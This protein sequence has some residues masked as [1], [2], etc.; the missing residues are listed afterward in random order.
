MNR[1][2]IAFLAA[3]LL[4]PLWAPAP[5]EAQYFGR[6]KVQFETFDFRILETPHFEI[7]FYDDLEDSIED[8]ARLADRWYER[9]A[10]IF[11]RELDGRQSPFRSGNA[12]GPGRGPH[13]E[14]G[15]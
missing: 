8:L 5:A 12:Q 1:I 2:L 11:S 9:A 4:L 13:R 15:S 3:L 10:R 6:N 7:F 14:T